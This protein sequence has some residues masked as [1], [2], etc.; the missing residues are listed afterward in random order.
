M[1]RP[2]TTC[3]VC[4]VSTQ[5]PSSVE[6]TA[7]TV[8]DRCTRGARWQDGCDPGVTATISRPGDASSQVIY[9]DPDHQSCEDCMCARH[10]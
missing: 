5:G 8:Y 9:A 10:T 3:S 6:V 7:G 1:M 2:T 4:H